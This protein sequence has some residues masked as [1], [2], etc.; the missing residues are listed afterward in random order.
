LNVLKRR[1]TLALLPT[2]GGKSLCYQ[3]PALIFSGITIVV[4]PLISLMK[5][6]VAGLEESAISAA[7]LNSSLG[8]RE[9]R[10]IRARIQAG[11]VKLLYVAP[12]RVM[13][14]DFLEFVESL[15]VALIAID[16]AHCI[17]EWGH[18]FRPEYRK[19]AK[20]RDVFPG[21]PVIA[22]TATAT[23]KVREDIVRQLKFEKH[24]AFCGSFD[25]ANLI[26]R[27]RPKQETYSQILA[28]AEDHPGQ[29]GIIYCHSRA[30]VD[31]MAENLSADGISALPYHAGL[32]TKT[33][34]ANQEA[35]MQGRAQVVAA[36]IAFGMGIDKPDVRFVIHH[37]LPKNIEGYYQETGRAGRDG[38]PAECILFFSYSDKMKH[39]FF[40]GKMTDPDRADIA[41]RQLETMVTF[42]VSNRCRRRM[43]LR[44]FGEEYPKEN[45][46]MCDTCFG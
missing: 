35:F 41:R 15:S 31:R 44:Y 37:D 45:C 19:L 6:Q 4:S 33:R 25:R 13:K 30:A 17:S 28:Y 11:R 3:L 5:D 10:E 27:I 29:S 1:D 42:C 20:L 24:G 2:G 34:T 26:Y 16:E 14:P 9:E 22:L 38:L 21:T 40:I 39:E 8:V 18:D 43:L 7:Y 12:E 32:D 36:T 23:M 46:G